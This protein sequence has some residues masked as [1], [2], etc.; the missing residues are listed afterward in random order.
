MSAW[1]V[2]KDHIDLLVTAAINCGAL[3]QREISHLAG[4]PAFIRDFS[5]DQVGKALWDANQRSLTAR[6]GDRATRTL[7]A[8]RWAAVTEAAALAAPVVLKACNCFDYQ[9]CEV[10]RYP[11]TWAAVWIDRLREKQICRVAGY[12]AAPWGFDRDFFKHAA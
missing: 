5:A 10:D 6:Y 7:P 11:D 12:E 2:S 9:A 4:A 8:Y 1:L 3:E